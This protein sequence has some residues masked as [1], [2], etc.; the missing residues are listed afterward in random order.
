MPERDLLVSTRLGE[1]TAHGY[2]ARREDKET[3]RSD[4]SWLANAVGDAVEKAAASLGRFW[5]PALLATVLN[6]QGGEQVRAILRKWES[7]DPDVLAPL[8]AFE[9]GR[10]PLFF[11]IWIMLSAEGDCE[12]LMELH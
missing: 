9:A 3:K 12:R 4:L 2:L 7:A 1:L 5:M 11:T 10:E 8:D 6:P